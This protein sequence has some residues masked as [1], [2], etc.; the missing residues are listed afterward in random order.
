[1][2]KL[3]EN[4]WFQVSSIFLLGLII[5]L[6]FDSLIFDFLD[7]DNIYLFWFI[8]LLGFMFTIFFISL[9]CILVFRFSFSEIRM[10]FGFMRIHSIRSL[11]IGFLVMVFVFLVG[12]LFFISGSN[13]LSEMYGANLG[14]YILDFDFPISYLQFSLPLFLLGI[15]VMIVIVFTEEFLFRGLIIN[16]LA[17]DNHNKKRLIIAVLVSSFLFS[18]WHFVSEPFLLGSFIEFFVMGLVF[19]LIF[20]FSKRNIFGV[21]FYHLMTNL[22]WPAHLFR[23]VWSMIYTVF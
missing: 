18:L 3:V 23:T 22:W 13:V 5:S 1:M 15:F 17:K 9:F 21:V 12:V 14:S 16:I 10:K 6:I 2:K 19:S 8:F 7:I 11:L 4:K 20:L